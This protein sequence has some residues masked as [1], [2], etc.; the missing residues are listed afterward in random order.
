MAA[1]SKLRTVLAGN[2]SSLALGYLSLPVL[3]FD[4]AYVRAFIS[5]ALLLLLLPAL[6]R[7][8][9]LNRFDARAWMIP[10]AAAIIVSLLAGFPFGPFPWDWFKHWALIQQLARHPWSLN[11]RIHGTPYYLRYYLAAYLVP[12]FAHHF[13]PLLPVWLATGAW[14]A[15]GY[16]LVFRD[17]S[18]I[19][20]NRWHCAA[21][22]LLMLLLGGADYYAMGLYR[23]LEGWPLHPALAFHDMQWS[24]QYGGAPLEFSPLVTSLTWVPQQSIA[25]FLVAAMLLRASDARSLLQAVLGYGL[26]ALWSPYGMIGSLP[27]L[28]A[29]AAGQRRHLMNVDG[30]LA[31]SAGLACALV[32]ASYLSTDLHVA[33]SCFVCAPRRLGHFSKFLPFLAFELTPFALILGR[34]L[35][36]NLHCRISLVTLLLIPIAHGTTADFVMRGSMGPLFVLAL[37]SAQALLARDVPMRRRLI[38]ACALALCLPTTVSEIVYLRTAG[39]AHSAIIETADP[40][41]LRW[42]RTFATRTDYSIDELF[43]TCGWQY[44]NQYF[45]NRRPWMLRRD[46]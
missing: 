8:V 30:I 22:V 17:V 21:A 14:F 15:L 41:R 28:I 45:A 29:V 44:L 16:A 31:T 24:L 9:R 6:L 2:D 39:R 11:V 42:M 3:I 38:Q 35:L 5:V 33:G 19:G 25:T 7:N 32:C 4:A 18:T 12:A 23:W 13:L 46:R 36:D 20:D 37:Y 34:R 26:L 43:N 1:G 10:A 40:L 27:L